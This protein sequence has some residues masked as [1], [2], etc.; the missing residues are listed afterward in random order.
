M[1]SGAPSPIRLFATAITKHW[2]A[3][4]SCAAFTGLAVYVAAT[5]KGNGWVV[6]GSAILAVLFFLLAAY[7]TWRDE[8]DKYTSQVARNLRPDIRGEAFNFS[9]SGIH[10]EGQEY[11]HWSASCDVSFDM[12]LCNQ[13]P[14]NTTLQGLELNGSFLTP[15]VAFD[16]HL[17]ATALRQHPAFPIGLEMPQGIGKRIT[18]HA[19]ATVDGMRITDVPAIPMDHLQIRIVDAFDQK[20]EVRIR[21][22]ERL[23]FGKR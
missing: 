23:K 15:P 5:N 4:M 16:L 9:G 10:W 21:R 12:L 19:M 11:G 14:V 6:G 17:S 22:G 20:H 8:H 3:L 13:K 2:W 18:V 7:R 1:S